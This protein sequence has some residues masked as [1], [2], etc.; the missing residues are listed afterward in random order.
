M[1]V[2]FRRSL[3]LKMLPMVVGICIWASFM[4]PPPPFILIAVYW[5]V[6]SL[7]TY[8]QRI[9]I[10]NQSV[11][12]HGYAGGIRGPVSLSKDEVVVC[13]YTKIA[14][15]GRGGFDYSFLEIRGSGKG[16]RVWRWGWG[17][18]Q[19]KLLFDSLNRWLADTTGSSWMQNQ[20]RCSCRSA[21]AR[22]DRAC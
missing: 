19:R 12:M 7:F 21:I 9:V 3:R 5:V 6:T 14:G 18:R 17:R 11:T 10:D 20:K 16:I 4:F 22:V 13:A 1:T 15:T 2:E 8:S